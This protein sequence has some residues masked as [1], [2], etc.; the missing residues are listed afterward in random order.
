M[1]YAVALRCMAVLLGLACA[2]QVP[3]R[4][5]ED[6]PVPC[7]VPCAAAKYRLLDGSADAHNAHDTHGPRPTA[8]EWYGARCGTFA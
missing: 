3:R 1:G 8:H 4:C 6:S 7:K 5:L 2:S